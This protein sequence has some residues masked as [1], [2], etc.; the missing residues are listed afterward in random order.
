MAAQQEGSRHH[1]NHTRHAGP[2]RHLQRDQP[3]SGKRGQKWHF[4]PDR[5]GEGPKGGD[6]MI[7]LC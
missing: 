4:L 7:Y 2:P 5:K 6:Q 3:L 1:R